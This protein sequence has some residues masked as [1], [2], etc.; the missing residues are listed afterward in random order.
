[1]AQM[2]NRSGQ[3]P[4]IYIYEGV[5][6]E[7]LPYFLYEVCIYRY[8]NS[9]FC[10]LGSRFFKSDKPLNI[11]CP[12]KFKQFDGYTIEKEISLIGAPYQFIKERNLSEYKPISKT[13]K[14]RKN[15]TVR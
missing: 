15:E 4:K 10:V 7:A 9:G 14:L 2:K 3:R 12:S 6:I 13:K 1:M 5:K 8:W 11:K